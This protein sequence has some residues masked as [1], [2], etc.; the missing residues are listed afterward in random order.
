[1]NRTVRVAAAQCEIRDDVAANRATLVD[2]VRRAAEQ[3][4]QLVVLPEFG[5]HYS[6]YESEEHAWEVATDTTDPDDPFVRAL[7]AAAGDHGI[8][9]VANSTVRRDGEGDRPGQRRITVTQLPM[10]G[11]IQRGSLSRAPKQLQRVGLVGRQNRVIGPLTQTNDP[12]Q[13][14]ISL[15]GTQ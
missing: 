12:L 13:R 2:M 15:T 1:M 10:R 4:A 9:V 3:G 6:I 14:F 7:S 5:N 11:G 8:W